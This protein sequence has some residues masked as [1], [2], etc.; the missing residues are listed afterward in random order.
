MADNLQALLATL[1]SVE[2]GGNTKA[3]LKGAI[4]NL[5]DNNSFLSGGGSLDYDSMSMLSGTVE[6]RSQASYKGSISGRGPPLRKPK[7]SSNNNNSST[8]SVLSRKNL[9]KQQESMYHSAPLRRGGKGT[10]TGDSVG[11][12]SSM[13][14]T[15]GGN[16]HLNLV[17]NDDVSVGSLGTLGGGYSVASSVTSMSSAY[18]SSTTGGGGASVDVAGQLKSVSSTRTKPSVKKVHKEL[19][20]NMSSMTLKDQEDATASLVRDIVTSSK[21]LSAAGPGGHSKFNPRLEKHL[22]EFKEGYDARYGKA[23]KLPR[24]T[25]LTDSTMAKRLADNALAGAPTE[26]ELVMAHDFVD[27][28]LH[29]TK[30]GQI[31][32]SIDSMVTR[33]NIE[34]TRATARANKAARG[35]ASSAA[36]DD[37]SASRVNEGGVDAADDDADDDD[38]GAL[39]HDSDLYSDTDSDTASDMSEEEKRERAAKKLR[40]S[41]KLKARRKAEA[42][43]EAR[44]QG[45]KEALDADANKEV[46]LQ[47]LHMTYLKEDAEGNVVLDTNSSGFFDNMTALRKAEE[48][49]AVMR[50]RMEEEEAAAERAEKARDEAKRQECTLAAADGGLDDVDAGAGAGSPTTGS[51]PTTTPSSPPAGAGR[52]ESMRVQGRKQSVVLAKLEA[53]GGYGVSTGAVT[54]S[55]PVGT[56]TPGAVNTAD[57]VGDGSTASI[58]SSLLKYGHERDIAADLMAVS[59]MASSPGA[60]PTSAGAATADTDKGKKSRVNTGKDRKSPGLTM[61]QPPGGPLVI[62]TV[63]YGIPYGLGLKGSG[64][65]RP[66]AM[67]DVEKFQQELASPKKQPLVALVSGKAEKEEQER[68]RKLEEEKAEKARERSA[69]A[70]GN[71]KS[72]LLSFLEEE[73]DDDESIVESLGA[74]SAEGSIVSET[75]TSLLAGVNNFHRKQATQSARVAAGVLTRYQE[76]QEEYLQ[77]K[78]E[79]EESERLHEPWMDEFKW[80]LHDEIGLDIDAKFMQKKLAEKA[81]RLMMFY[82]LEVQ[83]KNA[84]T[85]LRDQTRRVANARLLGAAAMINRMGRGMI[86]RQRCRVLMGMMRERVEAKRKKEKQAATF[87]RRMAR[88]IARNFRLYVKMKIVKRNLRHRRSATHMQRVVRGWLARIYTER[89]RDWVAWQNFN[90]TKIQCSF[91]QHLAR[92]RVV[93]FRKLV[94]VETLILEY[95]AAKEAVKDEH[96][97]EGA[98]T[99]IKRYYRGYKARKNLAKLIYWSRFD[100]AITLQK[101]IR[102]HQGRVRANALMKVKRAKEKTVFDAAACM[103]RYVRGVNARIVFAEKQVERRKEVARKR[104]RKKQYLENA[105]V[106][107]GKGAVLTAMRKMMPFRYILTWSKA[108]RIQKF[109]RGHRVRRRVYLM[110]IRRK[111]AADN[112]YFF[113]KHIGA[114]HFQRMFRGFRIRRGLV[115]ELRISAAWKIQCF[116]RQFF[117]RQ[118]KTFHQVRILFYCCSFFFFLLL[119]V[120]SLSPSYPSIAPCLHSLTRHDV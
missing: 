30:K 3:N 19:L 8:N 112:A 119:F 86:A 68:S 26:D 82:I 31:Y 87:L 9:K 24:L 96:R 91:R 57:I 94:A 107:A 101:H 36:T 65:N 16:N 104:L 84:F 108:L 53:A 4:A 89:L 58:G 2:K 118:K 18:G 61:F 73:E 85:F 25:T 27:K 22:Q 63:N 120:F 77:I 5:E 66:M 41:R 34:K 47:T 72:S 99:T 12:P 93:L 70:E 67:S 29:R 7:R 6:G 39:S 97:S 52:R 54:T 102:G 1:S 64:L 80:A 10:G 38:S 92:R 42:D 98:H 55:N 69:R 100:K 15:A 21:L 95:E 40:R 79:H 45:A 81:I 88:I 51:P 115:R 20:D 50:A 28:A 109:W 33:Q 17:N 48:A 32:A 37:A 71:V 90:I 111:I 49:R 43:K 75:S 116:L 59:G 44:K 117:A 35:N 113:G 106:N 78:S 11:G 62:G 23:V 76:R 56:G 13:S 74:A 83:L 46:A 114:T 103:Q 60:T 14:M 110:I 105:A